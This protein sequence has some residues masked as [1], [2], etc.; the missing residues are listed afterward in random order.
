MNTKTR[1]TAFQD[2][3]LPSTL[4]TASLLNIDEQRTGRNLLDQTETVAKSLDSIQQ[5]FTESTARIHQ[6][7]NADGVQ[8]ET[9]KLRL[10]LRERL[11]RT[12]AQIMSDINERIASLT[13]RLVAPPADAKDKIALVI[14][15]RQRLRA[16]DPLD[17]IGIFFEACRTRDAVTIEAVTSCPRWDVLVDDDVLSKGKDIVLQIEHPDVIESL[18]ATEAVRNALVQAI[19]R[20]EAFCQIR[21]DIVLTTATGEP[22]FF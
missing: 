10:N 19:S 15:S 4:I 21:P 12:A 13:A 3:D 5:E 7:S 20:T 8:L 1:Y 11:D 14:E 2:V 6:Y 22:H 9:G 17:V 18:K 16:L